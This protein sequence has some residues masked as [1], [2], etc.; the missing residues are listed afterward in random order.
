M[1]S[2]NRLDFIESTADTGFV[3][4][5]GVISQ[6]LNITEEDPA[7]LESWQGVIDRQDFTREHHIVLVYLLA[8]ARY[9]HPEET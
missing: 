9:P 5:L 2:K 6:H 8:Y 1:V 3:Q 4:R 7:F